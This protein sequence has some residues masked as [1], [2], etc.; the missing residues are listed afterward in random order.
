LSRAG[1]VFLGSVL[2]LA[3][4]CGGEEATSE[5]T[6]TVAGPNTDVRVYW[7]RDGK[8]WP[9][10]RTVETT[11]LVATGAVAELLV[12]PSKQEKAD[13]ETATAIPGSLDEAQ[14]DIAG[15]VAKVKLSGGLPKA[16]ACQ[17]AYTLTQF[18]DV[19]AVEIDGKRHTRRSCEAVTPAILVESP[20]PFERVTS[21]L[22]VTGTANTFEATF[23]Y[24][25]TDTDGRIVA[26]DFVTA[27]SGT[28]TRGTFDFTT[29]PFTVPFDGVGELIVYE[30]SAENGQ[31]IHLVEVPLRMKRT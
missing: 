30:L 29:K 6:T 8:V 5:T 4:G 28:G 18:P 26:E 19:Q 12:G 22:R 24:E 7:L 25:V 3:A 31:R 20:L 9:A 2:L 1:L 21:P 23:Q 27:T 17:L 15:G 13:L 11:D 10:E 16:G 14:L